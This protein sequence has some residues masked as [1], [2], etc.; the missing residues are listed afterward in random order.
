MSQSTPTKSMMRTMYLCAG[1]TLGMLGMAYAAVPLYQWFCQVTGYAGTTQRA[2]DTNGPVLEKKIT[3]RFDAN[4]SNALAWEFSPSEREVTVRIGEKSQTHYIAKNVGLRSSWGTASFNVS[5]QQAGAYF[6][7]IECF[8]FTEQQLASG[9]SV[10]MPVIFFIDP[11]IVKDPLLKDTD[12]ITLSYTF[13][14]DED[15]E[16]A[17]QE[18]LSDR[19][20]MGDENNSKL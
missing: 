3:V 1:L 5:P 9:E 16:K 15:A 8:C 13:F 6:N 2:E 17:N 19:S 12:A 14:P 18:K 7:K 20:P 4:I 10:D 11:D